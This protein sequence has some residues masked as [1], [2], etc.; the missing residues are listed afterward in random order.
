MSVTDA[1]EHQRKVN[2]ELGINGAAEDEMEGEGM[3]GIDE[4]HSKLASDPIND[5][6]ATVTRA[7]QP[8]APYSPEPQRAAELE[9]QLE[10]E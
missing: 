1:L 8:E 6:E 3:E 5:E 4:S 7:H 10:V 2:A 9:L